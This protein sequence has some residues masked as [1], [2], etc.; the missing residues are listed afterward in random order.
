MAQGEHVD[1]LVQE[2]PQVQVRFEAPQRVTAEDLLRDEAIEMSRNAALWEPETALYSEP[3]MK[4][5][6]DDGDAHE[7]ELSDEEYFYTY[8]ETRSDDM[9]Q[10]VQAATQVVNQLVPSATQMVTQSATTTTPMTEKSGTDADASVGARPSSTDDGSRPPEENDRR[11]P[12][13]GGEPKRSADEDETDMR[14]LQRDWTRD[15]RARYD[16]ANDEIMNVIS[17]MGGDPKQYKKERRS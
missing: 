1:E 14:E 2:P 6:A 4:E 16:A 9:V 8:G 12:R 11:H 5:P 13:E 17:A 15:V 7:R 10:V 3:P